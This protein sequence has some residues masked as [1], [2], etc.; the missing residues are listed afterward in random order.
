M[1]RVRELVLPGGGVVRGRS[2]RGAASDPPDWALYAVDRLPGPFP[3]PW[4]WVPW[5][6]FGLPDDD[7]DARAAI[8]EAFVR[9]GRGERVEVACAGG[10]GRTGTVLAALAILDGLSADEAVA[11]VRT[12]YRPDAVETRGQRDW[13]RRFEGEALPTRVDG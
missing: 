12:G 9:V 13:L 6:D 11:W 5:A 3:W 2:L 7:A 10:I 4:R 8:T 1:E